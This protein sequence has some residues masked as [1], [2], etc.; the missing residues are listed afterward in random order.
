MNSNNF[1]NFIQY[2]TA[3]N[4]VSI[5]FGHVAKYYLKNRSL[6]KNIRLKSQSWK[7]TPELIKEELILVERIKEAVDFIEWKTKTGQIKSTN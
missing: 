5:P 6:L 4:S 1:E 7:I 2:N 3:K